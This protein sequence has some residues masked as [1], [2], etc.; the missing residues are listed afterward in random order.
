MQQEGY[1]EENID[2][3]GF[4]D[5]GP[6]VVVPAVR[7]LVRLEELGPLIRCVTTGNCELLPLLP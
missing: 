3:W 6:V 2:V 5:G 4:V 7:F 1:T